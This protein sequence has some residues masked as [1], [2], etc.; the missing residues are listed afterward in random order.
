[1]SKTV[2]SIPATI[3]IENVSKLYTTRGDGVSWALQNASV[4]LRTDEFVCAIGPSGCGKTTLLNIIAGFTAPTE[5]ALAIAGK[6]IVGPGP[7]R[8]V[9]F[10]EYALYPWLTA[11]RNVEFGLRIQGVPA[12]RREELSTRFLKLVGLERA[13]DQYPHEL[14]GGMRQRIAV[15]RALVNEPRLLLMDEPFAALD[16]MTRQTLQTELLRIW[17]ELGFGILFITHNIEEAVFLAQR[18]LVMTPH[19]GRIKEVIDLRLP[20]P[21]DPAD[22]P[23][24]RAYSPVRDAF[25]H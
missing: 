9:V 6:P 20:Y 2:R 7:D 14:S 22:P 16:A 10:Q 15:A 19:P 8:G 5:G 3:S 17:Q 21:R 4:D 25:Q 12:A 24:G 11:R 13:A 1:M 23:F 18:V